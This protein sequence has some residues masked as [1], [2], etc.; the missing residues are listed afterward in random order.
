MPPAVEPRMAAV[1]RDEHELRVM[2]ADKSRADGVVVHTYDKNFVKTHDENI[3]PATHPTAIVTWSS[4][5]RDQHLAI[6]SSPA[7]NVRA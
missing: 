2:V 6:A 4:N 3:I 5:S 7:G 1:F